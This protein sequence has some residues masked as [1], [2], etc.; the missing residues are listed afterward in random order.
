MQLILGKKGHQS[1][2]SRH[3]AGRFRSEGPAVLT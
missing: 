2:R 3:F 1:G